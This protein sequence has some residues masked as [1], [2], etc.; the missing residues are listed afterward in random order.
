MTISCAH[1]EDDRYCPAGDNGEAAPTTRIATWKAGT[2]TEGKP[3]L[4][5]ATFDG[6]DSICGGTPCFAQGGV[7]GLEVRRAGS[8]VCVGV[9]QK[10]KLAT[11]FGWIPAARWNSAD[12]SPQP[13]SRWAGVWQNE[14][15]KITVL[16]TD[17]GQ[18]DI[19]GHA[20]RDLGLGT[21][22]IYGDFA[23]TGKPEDGVVTG[24][25]DYGCKVSVR[26]LGAYLVMADNGSCGG[27]GVSFSGMYRL[28]HH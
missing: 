14:T 22:E 9:P 3:A 2:V 19:K 18:L 25:G 1:A 17:D 10:G 21:E 8:S 4:L 12:S 13:R 23:I 5:R 24:S 28:R 26:L 11:M 27:A 15:A 20:V 7:A 6:P 16:S